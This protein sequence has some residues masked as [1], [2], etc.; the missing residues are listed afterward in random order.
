MNFWASQSRRT[1]FTY[2]IVVVAE[3][4]EVEEV[5]GWHMLV[6]ADVKRR[7]KGKTEE[8]W[9]CKQSRREWRP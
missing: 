5:V 1:R 4:L 6:A 9:K 3:I 2:E 8:L 7:I